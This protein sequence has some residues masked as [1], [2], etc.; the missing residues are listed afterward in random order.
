MEKQQLP[1]STRKPQQPHRQ[2]QQHRDQQPQT[3][4]IA[5]NIG[6]ILMPV[7]INVSKN[8]RGEQQ[9]TQFDQLVNEIIATVGKKLQQ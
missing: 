1:N 6:T 7:T 3:V 5:V 4:N 9:S 2:L 8:K